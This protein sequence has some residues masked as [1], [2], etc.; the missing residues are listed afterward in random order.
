MID[1]GDGRGQDTAPDRMMMG[2]TGG[3]GR[4]KAGRQGESSPSKASKQEGSRAEEP[5]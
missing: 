2:R 5:A 3:K 1:D 4:D